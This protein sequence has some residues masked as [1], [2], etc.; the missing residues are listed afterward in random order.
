MDVITSAFKLPS[1]DRPSMGAEPGGNS[2]EQASGKFS[3]TPPTEGFDF[4]IFHFVF[5]A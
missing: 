2:F 3:S 4:G 1:E 5:V